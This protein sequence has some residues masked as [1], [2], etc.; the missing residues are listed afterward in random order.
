MRFLSLL[1]TVFCIIYLCSSALTVVQW[2][3]HSIL[4]ACNCAR[5]MLSGSRQLSRKG[6]AWA[7]EHCIIN[8][9]RF[10]AECGKSKL[11][12]ARFVSLCFT[13]FG[14]FFAVLCFFVYCLYF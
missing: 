7:R 10:L 1:F 2:T 9:P 5:Y 11:N 14:L 6:L 4:I 13:F 3:Q 12:Q 8:P